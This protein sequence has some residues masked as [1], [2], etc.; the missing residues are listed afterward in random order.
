MP[1]LLLN[2]LLI[3]GEFSLGKSLELVEYLN[4]KKSKINIFSIDVDL[5]Y[6]ILHSDLLAAVVSC[7]E[8][9]GTIHL[10]NNGGA[11]LDNFTILLQFYLPS[12]IVSF[13]DKLFLKKKGIFIGSCVAPPL[14][15]NFLAG[16]D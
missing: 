8:K 4:K 7:I 16:P 13:E 2:D 12:T 10:Q 14:W 6:S 15:N 3:E 1:I 11:P 9:N 5:F